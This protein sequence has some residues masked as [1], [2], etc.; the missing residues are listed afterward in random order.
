METGTVVG[1]AGLIGAGVFA[2]GWRLFSS[3]GSK[4][5]EENKESP[6]G[7]VLLLPPDTTLEEQKVTLGLLSQLW[8]KDQVQMVRFD[9]ISKIWREIEVKVEKKERVPVFQHGDITKFYLDRVRGRPFFV[10]DALD[11]TI[12]LLELLDRDGNCASV[13][14]QNEKEPEK[15]FDVDTF[16]LLARIPLYRHSINVA[17]AAMDK[18]GTGSVVPKAALAALAHDLGKIPFYYG[19]YY[20]TSM[21]PSVGL[22]V[23]ESIPRLKNIKWFEEISAAIKNHHGQSIEYLDSLIREAD[24]TARRF[25]INNIA[26]LINP[27]DDPKPAQASPDTQ[28]PN[29]EIAGDTTVQQAA[30]AKSLDAAQASQKKST[31]AASTDQVQAAA[32]TNKPAEV[33]CKEAQPQRVQI[34]PPVEPERPERKRI[35]RQL[36]NLSPW[37]DADRFIKELTKIINTTQTGDKFWSAL[38]LGHYVYVKPVGMFGL[39]VR[40]S[41]NDPEVV[42]AG[43]SE[44]DRD[45]Y[46]Y[47]VVME[48]KKKKDLVATEFLNGD[49]FG[50]VFLHNPN[51]DST[52]TK[53]FLIPFRSDYFGEDIARFESRRNTLMKK[54]TALVPAFKGEN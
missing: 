49:R 36:K 7:D 8:V 37:F 17:C 51:T 31:D 26:K 24:Q 15:L 18:V 52:A 42:A 38:A 10:G 30:V 54:T 2:Y 32:Q 45:D 22:A 14:R 46:L 47:S 5:P 3:G 40:H 1:V 23:A 29:T 35:P 13:V 12:D 21:H 48:L 44:Q 20:K 28:R 27:E 39:V 16:N 11:T 41:K 25:E 4:T 19:K 53:Q 6:K 9:E 33:A 34:T 50:A 43:P